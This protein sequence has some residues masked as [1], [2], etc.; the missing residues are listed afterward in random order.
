MLPER[1]ADV[2]RE[3]VVR[4]E[5]ARTI[6][7]MLLVNRMWSFLRQSPPDREAARQFM[8]TWFR[9]PVRAARG[10]HTHCSAADGR[11]QPPGPTDRLAL[12]APSPQ[13]RDNDEGYLDINLALNALESAYIQLTGK[14]EAKGKDTG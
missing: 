10:S 5:A 2:R 1:V 3:E 8:Y 12:C 14:S 13:V 11:I 7:R 4:H 9:K 6:T